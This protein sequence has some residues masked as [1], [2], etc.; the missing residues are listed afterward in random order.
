MEAAAEWW[1]ENRPAAPDAL[2]KTISA[3][4]KLLLALTKTWT[5]RADLAMAVALVAAQPGCFV[6]IVSRRLRG[7]RRI[8]LV[9]IDYHV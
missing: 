6:P 7:V 1:K 5:P 4:T 3:P 8:H 9:R 2:T